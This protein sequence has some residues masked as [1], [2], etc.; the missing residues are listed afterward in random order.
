[1]DE[2]SVN[3]AQYN[4][5]FVLGGKSKNEDGKPVKVPM[6]IDKGGEPARLW[7]GKAGPLC[8]LYAL[9]YERDVWQFARLCH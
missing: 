1:M 5:C 7:G 3:K 4:N 8:G 2:L 9:T 6:F